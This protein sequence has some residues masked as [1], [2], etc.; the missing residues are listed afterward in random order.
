M[1]IKK[2]VIPAAGYGTRFLPATKASPKEMLPVVDKPVIQ[3]V[4]EEAVNAGITH[5]IIIS[6]ANKRPIEDHFDYNF[7]LEYRL[8]EVGKDKELEQI[9]KI[10]DM[11]T[12]TY[13]R[14]KEH[15]G[16]GH[17][18]L[19]AREIINHEP[20]AVLW[21][22]NFMTANPPH[23]KQMIDAY[24]QNPGCIL[25]ALKTDSP[26]DTKKFAYGKGEEVSKGVY[27]L[28]DIIE[29]PGPDKAPSDIA[30]VGGYILEPEIFEVLDQ[31]KPG[32][33][34][35]IWLTDAIRGLI[36]G[37]KPVYAKEIDGGRFYD[38]GDKLEY[39][40]ANIDH[41]LKREDLKDGLEKYLKEKLKI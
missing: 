1:K 10:A 20:F 36:S 9:R 19:C 21:G 28:N 7:E 25:S 4:V 32:F 26:E 33:G 24:D 17:A 29:K 3:Y 14:Q 22:D 16:N 2:A 8:H 12:F 27:K 40:K 35:E 30:I 18:V 23:M 31:M 15:L 6:G 11:A 5:I 13:I 39:L 37:G 41:A 38:C 34:G